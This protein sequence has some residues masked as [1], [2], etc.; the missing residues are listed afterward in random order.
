MPVPTEIHFQNPTCRVARPA[1]KSYNYKLP[2]CVSSRYF[3]GIRSLWGLIWMYT[4]LDLDR[5]FE[6]DWTPALGD[7]VF[8][9][10]GFISHNRNDGSSHIAEQL[11]SLG[12]SI[13]HDED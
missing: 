8:K 11:R 5:I 1:Q 10:D 13:W 6:P 3:G 7:R 12:A 4:M 2:L 9:F